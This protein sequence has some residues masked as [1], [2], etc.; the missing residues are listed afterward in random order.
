MMTKIGGNAPLFSLIPGQ[1]R[2]AD[3]LDHRDAPYSADY[4][5]SAG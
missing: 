4:I 3:V 1:N 2:G 5:R